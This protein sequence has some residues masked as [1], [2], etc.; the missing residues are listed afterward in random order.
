MIYSFSGPPGQGKSEAISFFKEEGFLTIPTER[1]DYTTSIAEFQAIQEKTLEDKFTTLS[2]FPDDMSLIVESSFIDMFIYSTMI[3]G[4]HYDHSTW[5][6][7]FYDKCIR[8]Q[9]IIDVTVLFPYISGENQAMNEFAAES[10]HI[11]AEHY[12]RLNNFKF[13]KNHGLD[14]NIKFLIKNEELPNEN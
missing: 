10:F 11:L 12:L 14:D 6:K 9:E 2:D 3:L 4:I 5:L 1:A 13:L 7:S 8:Y